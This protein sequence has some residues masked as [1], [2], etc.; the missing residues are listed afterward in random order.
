M[1]VLGI[2]TSCDETSAALVDGAS[3]L[4]N[5]VATQTVHQEYGG[6]VPE[7]ASRA[8]IRQLL[9]VIRL[10]LG[11]AG[12]SWS[13]IQGLAVTHGPGLAGSLLIGLSTCKG[14]ALAL[15]L[16]WIGINHLE[17]HLM[18]VSASRA[19]PEYPHIALL[20]SGGHTLLVLAEAPLSYRIIG[21]TLD[22][23]AGEA[24]DKVAK[25]L[26]LGYPGG[27]AIER[28][29]SAGR[30]QAVSFPRALLKGDDLNFSFSGLKTAVLYHVRSRPPHQVENEI[31]DIS[32]SF[33]RAVVDVLVAKSIRAL[34][35]HD[36]RVLLLA[37]GVARNT[38]LRKALADKCQRS[39]IDFFV[40]PAELC[41]D[42][43]AMIARAG[44]E[45]LIRGQRSNHDLDAAPD[46]SLDGTENE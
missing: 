37:G 36:I 41:T 6:V 2:E 14:L 23:A 40:P 15:D 19:A 7:F 17:G 44:Y 16:P 8:H 31:A 20:V 25:T 30:D 5:I 46:L 21:R 29:A 24:F 11:K 13:D 4:S 28:S 12:R 9:P 45:R 34:E 3:V 39:G 22:D 10:A 33:Q 1:I 18:A 27:P 42:N 32:A 38:A 35:K 26:G 43:A